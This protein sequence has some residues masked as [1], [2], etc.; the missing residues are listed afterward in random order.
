TLIPMALSESAAASGTERH[1]SHQLLQL[2]YQQQQHYA[3]ATFKDLLLFGNGEHPQLVQLEYFYKT[4]IESVLTND[5]QLFLKIT[6]SH[7]HNIPSSTLPQNTPSTPLSRLPS[8]APALS[9]LTQAILLRA[10]DGGQNYPHTTHQLTI[11]ETDF[12]EHRP[13]WMRGLCVQTL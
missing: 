3:F 7:V 1:H 8:A 13:A 5:N 6:Y 11:G 10:R 9:P 12:G 4:L 2:L